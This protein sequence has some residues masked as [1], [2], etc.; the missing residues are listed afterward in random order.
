MSSIDSVSSSAGLELL[1][2]NLAKSI[3]EQQG[4]AVL[5]LIS[6]AATVSPSAGSSAPQGSL[7]HSINIHV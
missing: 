1:S 2:A 3:Q 5:K 6:S 7:G 4:Q